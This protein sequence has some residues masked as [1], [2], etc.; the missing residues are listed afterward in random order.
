MTEAIYDES[1]EIGRQAM[2]KYLHDFDPDNGT[3]LTNY[4]GEGKLPEGCIPSLIEA[5]DRTLA[6][7][8]VEPQG[9]Y[10]NRVFYDKGKINSEE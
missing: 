10:L 9:L 1:L 5:R 3:A 2:L 6:G 8:T 4:I 7:K